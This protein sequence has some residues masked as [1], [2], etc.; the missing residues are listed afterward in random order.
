MSREY[1]IRAE[2][3]TS[4]V[5]AKIVDSIRQDFPSTEVSED[6]KSLW[7]PSKN[8]AWIDFS[9]EHIADGLSIV[10]NMNGPEHNRA[11]LLIETILLSHS[12]DF[13]IEEV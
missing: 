6:K 11:I 12:I 8:P 7:I 13:N 4:G 10:S 5:F 3:I 2:G 9:A 1:D